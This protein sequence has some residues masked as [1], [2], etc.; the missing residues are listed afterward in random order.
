MTME[1]D[2]FPRAKEKLDH[3]DVVS[4]F[5]WTLNSAG[6]FSFKLLESITT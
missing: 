3:V 4:G 6:F 1:C 2:P 5:G